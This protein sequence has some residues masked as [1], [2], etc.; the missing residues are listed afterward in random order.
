MAT[1][2]KNME[3]P[4]IKPKKKKPFFQ[5]L[6]AQR[7]LQLMVLPGLILVIVFR[8]FPIYGLQ[9]AW[10]DFAA[11]LGIWASPVADPWYKHFMDFF[12]DKYFGQV[13]YNTICLSLLKIVF[14]FPMPILMAMLLNE[15][16]SNKIKS[17][18]QGISYLPHF[19]S[20]VIC[21]GI[22]AQ[23]F[24]RDGGTINS[25]LQALGLQDKENPIFWFGEPSKFWGLM[26]CFDIWKETGWS[27]IIYMAA[28]AGVDAEIYEAARIDGANRF[29]QAWYITLPSIIPTVVIMLILRTGS[30]L[31]TGFDQLLVFRNSIVAD[32]ARTLDLYVYDVGMQQGRYGYATA[33]GLFKSLV[34]FILVFTTNKIASKAEM[35]IW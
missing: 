31:D 16:K 32:P 17:L 27:A 21:Y 13:M 14:G 30:V 19:I 10:K 33:V 24:A 18:V 35:G 4:I 8:F 12:A 3:A 29:K 2:M 25:I 20:W 7:E 26:I 15:V 6:W 34:A 5:R 22:L 1:E 23:I 11:Q 9:L 28:I